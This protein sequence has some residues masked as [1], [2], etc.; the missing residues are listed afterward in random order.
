[1]PA[2]LS[3]PFLRWP[4]I[5]VGIAIAL[6]CAVWISAFALRDKAIDRWRQHES[7][8]GRDWNC[9]SPSSEGF[10]LSYRLSCKA[11]T[12]KAWGAKPF[13]LK[14]GPVILEYSWLRPFTVRLNAEPELFW[15]A[16]AQSAAAKWKVLEIR[17]GKR[18]FSDPQLEIRLDGFEAK[19]TNGS[20]GSGPI[21]ADAISVM[22]RA[23]QGEGPSLK[24]HGSL[25]AT[26]IQF[27]ALGRML[28]GPEPLNVNA[29]II[30]DRF[31]LLLQGE[32]GA[33]LARWRSDNGS[34]SFNALDL[35]KE[36]TQI[37]G[38][39]KLTLDAMNRPAG[40]LDLETRGLPNLLSLMTTRQPQGGAL[41]SL[42]T[43]KP[44]ADPP[45][46]SMA[47]NAKLVMR[48]G[49]LWLG[50]LRTPVALHPLF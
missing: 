14:T 20:E 5:L 48:D 50:P 2:I 27:A 18:P 21:G 23:E 24:L 44:A 6:W 35:R 10:P 47:F 49:A 30:I 15:Q 43:R 22:A 1:M 36:P 37:K 16:Q 12:L 4:L 45:Q 32:P 13:E 40:T 33:R 28:P 8:R 7:A 25:N 34:L 19:V 39:G 46:R 11:V 29:N 3:K 26:N 31:D 17:A 42:L 41:A 9:A 38:E